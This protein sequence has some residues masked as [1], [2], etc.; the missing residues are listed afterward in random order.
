MTKKNLRLVKKISGKTRF[1]HPFN[2]ANNTPKMSKKPVIDTPRRVRIIGD[3]ELMKVK[4]IPFL[5]SDVFR[6]YGVS[7]ATGWRIIK[8]KH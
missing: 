7:K 6:R 2:S 3:C 1:Y 5:Y 4:G 8:E